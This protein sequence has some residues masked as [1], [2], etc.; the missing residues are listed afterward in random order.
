MKKLLLIAALWGCLSALLAEPAASL[1]AERQRA[2]FKV[3]DRIA[4]AMVQQRK[5]LIPEMMKEM[6]RLGEAGDLRAA[7]EYAMYHSGAVD[8][9]KGCAMAGKLF[10]E[11]LNL[12][13]KDDWRACQAVG[14]CYAYGMGCKRDNTAA[15]RWTE[16]SRKLMQKAAANDDPVAMLEQAFHTL[17]M[18]SAP[19]EAEALLHRLKKYDSKF[20]E[21]VLEKIAEE[22]KRSGK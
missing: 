9:E 21:Y 8:Y 7:F 16:K 22:K 1:P 19:K 17:M 12:A 14:M 13:K 3:Y 4:L 2:Y 20:A 5:E 15:D 11:L 10:P 6:S 18:G